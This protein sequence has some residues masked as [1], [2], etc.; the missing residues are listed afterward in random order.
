MLH[1]VVSVGPPMETTR[2]PGTRSR[3]RPGTGS[4]IQSPPRNTSRSGPGRAPLA[5]SISIIAGTEFHTVTPCRAISSAQC[6]G[7]R[8]SA[9]AGTTTAPPAPSSPNRSKADRS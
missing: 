5:R 7:S 2:T 1:T 6:A 4:G 9:A 8:R 3:S